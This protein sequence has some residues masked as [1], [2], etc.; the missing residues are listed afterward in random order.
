MSKQARVFLPVKIFQACLMIDRPTPWVVHFNLLHSGRLCS[1][2][3]VLDFVGKIFP[4]SNTLA[5]FLGSWVTKKKFYNIDTLWEPQ[6]LIEHAEIN[7]I[8]IFLRS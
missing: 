2:S 7:L 5:Y 6:C 8:N 3:K 1:Y 4:R